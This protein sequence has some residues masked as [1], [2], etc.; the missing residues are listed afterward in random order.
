MN[1]ESDAKSG[2][3]PRI[4]ISFPLA[5]CPA[6]CQYVDMVCIFCKSKT[7]VTNSRPQKRLGTTWRRRQCDKCLAIFSSI[8]T[9]D[10]AASIRFRTRDGHLVP[11][12]RD[13]LF[14]SLLKSLEHRRDAVTS[15]SALCATIIAKTLE[16]A[17]GAL[18]E[19]QTLVS[20]C[21][22]T[23]EAFDKP[24]ATHYHAYHSD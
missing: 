15:A 2:T 10:L 16:T 19:R 11:F 9:P 22:S 1:S 6:L 7:K 24:A 17:S 13:K 14:A 20:V 5:F 8:E 12:E 3:F 4:I 18:V 21:I 23:L